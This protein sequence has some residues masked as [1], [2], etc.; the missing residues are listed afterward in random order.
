MRR[1]D[2]TDAVLWRARVSRFGA[3][4]TNCALAWMCLVALVVAVAP[5]RG[6]RAQQLVA[7][8]SDPQKLTSQ[9]GTSGGAWIPTESFWGELLRG[10]IFAPPR[11]SRYDDGD[12][13]ALRSGLTRALPQES[14]SS[15]PRVSLPLRGKDRR[16]SNDE[17][18]EAEERP[19]PTRTYRT[20]CVRLCDGYYWPVN[21]AVTQDKF[22]DDAATCARTCGGPGEAKLYTYRNP[23]G[24]IDDMEDSDGKAYKKL[25]TAFLFRTKYEASCKCRPHP[26]EEASADRHKAYAYVADARKG[27]RVAQQKLKDLRV[28]LQVEAQIAIKTK[29]DLARAK[30]AAKAAALAPA[31]TIAAAAKPEQAVGVA[32]NADPAPASEPLTVLAV[33]K[34]TLIKGS[35]IQSG[36]LRSVPVIGSV[37]EGTAVKQS[38]TVRLRLGSHVVKE[39]PVS[40]RWSKRAAD[41]VDP[42]VVQR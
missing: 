38:S 39:V 22:K 18:D 4:P 3:A 12:N 20:M 21:Y 5:E 33:R 11:S 41:A 16:K 29:A 34:P 30:T 42:R 17:D 14:R 9:T 35:Q 32:E 23:G 6:H 26:W 40:S 19:A 10:T 8:V 25:Q 1:S 27:D 31:T 2:E 37:A 28:K 13:R 15:P 7:T 36:N 24:E